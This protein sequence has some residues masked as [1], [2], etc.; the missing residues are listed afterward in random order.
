[1]TTLLHQLPLQ[2]SARTPDA[3]ALSFAGQN[4]CYG[5]LAD[6]IERFAQGVLALG[7]SRGERVAIWLDKRVETVVAS[8]GATAAGGVFVPINPLLKPDQV[9]YILRD[10]NVRI[11][12]SSPERLT[13]LD[14]VLPDCHD[15]RHVLVT[16]AAP[17][18]TSPQ[19]VTEWGALGRGGT[20]VAHRVIDRDMAAILYTSGSTGR[21][22]GVVLSHRNMVAGAKSVASYLQNNA[23]D[24]LLAALPLSFDA[25]FSQLTTGFSVGARVVLLNYLLPRD[26]IKAMEREQ[27]T[28]LT[29]V[30]PLWIQLTQLE[31]P[32]AIRTHLRYFANTG[33]RM[34]L[35]TLKALR[36]RVPAAKPF[37]M[38]G[39]TEAFRATYLPP[40]EVDRR[41]DSIGKS[42][43][44]SE[45][46]VLREDG[47]PCAPHEPGELVQ[48]GALVAMG[49]WNDAEKTAERFRPLPSGAAGRENGIVIPEIA[50]FSGDT[51]RIDE[52]GFLYFIG[53]RD[54]M[55]KTSGYRVSPT[56][57]E[58][59]IYGTQ[60][61]GE[62]AA[63]GVEHP[64]LGQAI[65][66]V[67]SPPTGRSL[68]HATLLSECR[69]RLPAWQ[70][71]AHIVIRDGALP[72]NPNGKIDRKSLSAEFQTFFSDATK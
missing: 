3:P 19:T 20:K 18:L 9:A 27:V 17:T 14:A 58:E 48:R 44:N 43:P 22:K 50:V 29:A 67:V 69:T 49:Y 51:V 10:C 24:T 12:I 25:G 5:D 33:G 1:M 11:L 2:W 71:P 53:R 23:D 28:G 45:V 42:I 16:G 13:L 72:R 6:Q 36:Q 66:L 39:L 46:M 41:P 21:P 57:V 63:F 32:E 64:T 38:Y 37:L 70:V 52:E 8:F 4:L 56:E 60:L 30:P 47:T 55:I 34:P 7:L 26:V 68:D 65:I 15:L 62:C 40:E 59:V 31:W 61:V 35:E 54:E